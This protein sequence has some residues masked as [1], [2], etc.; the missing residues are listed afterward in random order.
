M[1]KTEESVNEEYWEYDYDD[2]TGQKFDVAENVSELKTEAGPSAAANRFSSDEDT[3]CD[4]QIVGAYTLG[5][6]AK[7]NGDTKRWSSKLKKE[8][9]QKMKGKARVKF[10]VKCKYCRAMF[11]C[12]EAMRYHI[13]LYHAKGIQKT[14]ACYLCKKTFAQKESLAPHMKMKH[15]GHSL[16]LCPFSMCT[17]AYARQFALNVHI[18]SK[19]TK[20]IAY[21]CSKCDEKFHDKGIRQYHEK[22]RHSKRFICKWCKKSYVSKEYIKIHVQNVHMAKP[23]TWAY[24]SHFI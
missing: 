7:N 19:H 12:K 6:D 9:R 13:P 3:E 1:F 14:I 5:V 23:R 18:N 24:G 8:K 4:V 11:D 22:T 17:N 20:K 2:Y 16:L 10:T 15:T 21:K